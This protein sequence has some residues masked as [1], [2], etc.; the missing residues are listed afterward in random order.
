MMSRKPRRFTRRIGER[1]YRKLFLIAAEGAKTEPQYFSMF[2]SR[3][4]TVQVTCLKCGHDS[5]PPQVLK[6]MTTWLKKNGLKDSDEAW[7]VVDKDQWTDAQLMELHLWAQSKGNYGFALSNPKFEYWLLLHFE[8]GKGVQS[9]RQCSERLRQHLPYYDKGIDLR[10]F[11]PDSI[12]RAVHRAELRDT[13]PCTD[14]PRTTGTTVYR[15]VE[16]LIPSEFFN[17]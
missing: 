2:N 16:Q 5:A 1:S 13:P 10:K 17:P 6:R 9:S 15:L 12:S 14:W 3:Q 11:T 8:E 4:A 7:L